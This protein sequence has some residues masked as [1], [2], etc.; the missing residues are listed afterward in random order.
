MFIAVSN[1][2][3]GELKRDKFG[4]LL[5]TK[6]TRRGLGLESV[7]QLVQSNGGMMEVEAEDG[8][9][10]VFVLLPEQTSLEGAGNLQTMRSSL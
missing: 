2:Y 3:D 10:R 4:K 7:E 5:S 6:S 9:F 8:V 1:G